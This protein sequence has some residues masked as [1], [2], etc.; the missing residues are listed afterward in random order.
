MKYCC[1]SLEKV[2]FPWISSVHPEKRTLIHELEPFIEELCESITPQRHNAVHTDASF[3][4]VVV[5]FEEY[6]N[7][8]RHDSCILLDV[9]H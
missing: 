8:L 1:G 2:S 5:L 6:L 4:D 9:I 7:V 3:Q